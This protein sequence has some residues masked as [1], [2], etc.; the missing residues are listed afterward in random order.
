MQRNPDQVERES[1][2]TIGRLREDLQGYS[3]DTEIT[4]GSTREAVPLIFY[5][6]KRRGDGL[7]QIELNEVDPEH[8]RW[9]LRQGG[10]ELLLDEVK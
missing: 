4:F 5:R 7:V 6:V 10:D 3:D 8:K 1:R 2:I 9:I